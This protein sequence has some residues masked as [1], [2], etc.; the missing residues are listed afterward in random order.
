MSF[1]ELVLSG[2]ERPE[3]I[4]KFVHD[5]HSRFDDDGATIFDYLGLTKEE[6]SKWVEDPN[7]LN[8]IFENRK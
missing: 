3:S 7:S 6:Y 8:E 4:D 5:W 1:V 2:Q